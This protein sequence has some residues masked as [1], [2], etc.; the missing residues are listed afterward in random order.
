MASNLRVD[1]ILPSSGTTL[2]I[3]TANGTTNFTGNVGI[4]GTLTYEDVTN[5]D[6]VGVVT[7]RNGIRVGTG[8]TV[9][10][11]GAGIVTYFG[12]GSNLTSLPAA[13]LTGT[14]PAISA[15][16]LTNIP[17]ANVTGTIPSAALTNVDLESIRKDIATLALQ[18]AVDT[19]KAEYNLQ[20]SFIDQFE[21]DSGLVTETNVDRQSDEYV[22]SVY[23]SASQVQV[24]QNVGTI[25]SDFTHDQANAYD[26]VTNQANGDSARKQTSS[27]S[28]WFGKDWGSGNTKYITGFKLG[29]TNNDGMND[30]GSV[31]SGCSLT[32]YGNTSN[33]TGTATNLGGLTNLNFRQNNHVDDYTKLSGLTATT[34]YRYHWINLQI[35]T[36]QAAN[37]F[38]IA[39][40][41]WFENTVT[42][43]A[44][45]TLIG[46][47]PNQASSARTKVSGVLLYKDSSGTATIGTDL[48]IYV[49]CNAGTNWHEVTSRTV[50]PDFSAGIKT[51]YLNETTCT[52]GTDIRYKVEWANQAAG[53]KVTQLH[54]IALNY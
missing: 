27:H 43:N 17:G 47:G 42:S 28:A 36:N 50:G 8:G 23:Q 45:G 26:G 15:T 20:D 51:I 31:T 22:S 6:S 49:T 41:Q 18:V 12:D 38:R 33:N 48:K 2:G 25:V 13:N 10:P 53:S 21:N 35:P 19:N 39:E 3:G 29:S 24:A 44:T 1:T 4:A 7:A 34:G 14:L 16:N 46:K 30:N 40:M 32:L 11:V 52:S 5:I 37:W 9:G 54:G